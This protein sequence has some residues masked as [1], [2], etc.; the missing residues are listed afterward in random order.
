MASEREPDS[1]NNLDSQAEKESS[2]EP[3]QSTDDYFENINK[4]MKK[5]SRFGFGKANKKESEPK[6]EIKTEKPKLEIPEPPIIAETPKIDET[7]TES[8]QPV[9]EQPPEQP[10]PVETVEPQPAP[11]ETEQPKIETSDEIPRAQETP[12]EAPTTV[13]SVP[14][15]IIEPVPEPA[16]GIPATVVIA[17]PEPEPEIKPRP[18]EQVKPKKKGFFSFLKRHKEEPAKP[19]TAESLNP[20]VPETESPITV[21]EP[22]STPEVSPVSSPEAEV[23]AVPTPDLMVNPPEIQPVIEP[24]AVVEEPAVKPIETPPAAAVEQPLNTQAPFDDGIVNIGHLAK[25]GKSRFPEKAVLSIGEYPIHLLLKSRLAY[26]PDGLLPLFIDKSSREITKWSSRPIDPDYIVGLDSEAD[27]H[28]WFNILPNVTNESPFITKL[29]SKPI[30]ELRE[31][32]IVSSIWDGV[33]SAL[34]PTLVAQFNERKIGSVALALMPSK[35]QPSE[36]QFNAFAA[37]GKCSILN[38]A[39]IVLLD[40]DSIDNYLGVD[41]RGNM[42]KGPDV[43]NYLLDLML[44]KETLVDEFNE[45]TKSF[46]AP[47]YTLMFGTG[48]S[49]R[50]Y[51]SIENILNTLLSKQFLPI[52]LASSELLYVLARVPSSLKDKVTRAK[53]EMAVANWFND[54]ATLKSIRISE[55]VYVEDTSDRIDIALFIGGF[56]TQKIFSGIEKK[57]NNMK[58]QAIKN[59]QLQEDEWKQI[60]KKLTD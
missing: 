19:L 50:V 48:A 45:L 29:L 46:D 1:E 43:L 57:V 37:V 49:I 11:S 10:T 34:L 53:I 22:M 40:R 60:V 38:S 30:K 54:K 39:T 33:G 18:V 55:P 23:P 58:N 2:A 52:D 21:E 20:T 25:S 32:L 8:V 17:E 42:L 3:I 9:I 31:S 4:R 24:V 12:V 41:R 5:K 47:I 35:V 15:P 27:T 59:G 28:L 6:K 44:S 16:V 7:K 13:E 14:E 56:S 26:R 51:G 36:S